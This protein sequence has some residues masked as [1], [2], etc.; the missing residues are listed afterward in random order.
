MHCSNTDLQRDTTAVAGTQEVE[1]GLVRLESQHDHF[2]VVLP[3]S[4]VFLLAEKFVDVACR[5]EHNAC[6]LNTEKWL[7]TRRRRIN[8]TI[9]F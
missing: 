1:S 7:S 4:R 3:L 5:T 6:A 2:L 8:R 9:Y